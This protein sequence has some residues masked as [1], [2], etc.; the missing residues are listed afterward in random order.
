MRCATIIT[1]GCSKNVVD[2][3]HLAAA[4][5]AQGWD[6]QMDAEPRVGDTLLINTC[7]F[8]GDAKEE[9]VNQIL[10]AGEWRR[11]KRVGKLLVFGCLSQRYPVELAQEIPEVDGWFGAR[12]LAPLLEYLGCSTGG[13]ALIARQLSTPEHY[14]YL[15]VAEGCDRGCAFCA[16]PQIRGRFHSIP[17]GILRQ[18]ALQLAEGGVKELILI[19]QEL[20]NYGYDLGQP[21]AL[22]E[23]VQALAKIEPLRWIRL[24]Y[25]Y[26]HNFPLQLVEWMANEPKACHYLDIPLQHIS[27][28]VLTA[29][30]RAHNAA[31]ARRLVE[32]LR[33]RI[34]DIALRTTLLVGFPG[35]T[36]RDIYALEQFMH[37]SEFDHLGIFTYSEE[38]GTY[39]ALHAK[40]TI[41]QAEK[42]A[43]RGHL[44][45]LQ[46]SIS[47]RR[48]SRFL[49]Q[50]LEVMVDAA[51]GLGEYIG[52]TRYDSPEVDGEV[53]VKSATVLTNGQIVPVEIDK[54]SEY[55]LEGTATL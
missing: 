18:E 52:R 3:E 13:H 34:P 26:P 51:A 43:R 37:D 46:Q 44:M 5:S 25:A 14:A 30:H 40:D 48:K 17:T 7:G 28:A 45:E 38:E 39:A 9:S 49:G 19:A 6:V 27:D 11:Q 22:L 55:D 31:E 15:K 24:H 1:L 12:E 50:K 21:N 33:T 41:P 23:L 47:A 10:V 8:I 36:D 20:T 2:S 29:M 53:L 32:M 16:I 35:E 42:E 54:T 4:L